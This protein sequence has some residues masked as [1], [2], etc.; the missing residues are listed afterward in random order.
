MNGPTTIALAVSCLALGVSLGG[1]V[2]QV[3][4]WFWTGPRIRVS[5][6]SG[7]AVDQP[8][9]P[10]ILVLVVSNRGRMPATIDQWDFVAKSTLYGVQ[11]WK[12]GPADP[13]KL[14]PYTEARWQQDEGETRQLL[15]QNNLPSYAHRW[16]MVPAI[17]IG[18]DWIYGKAPIR[19]WEPGHFGPDPRIHK[20]WRRFMPRMIAV[21]TRHGTGWQRAPRKLPLKSETLYCQDGT[22]RHA[23]RA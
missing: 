9:H 15:V 5:S 14:E 7:I 4:A 23:R 20:P 11:A 22:P 6:L 21:Q 13:Y 12:S 3:V 1:L 19:I 16:D 17:R 10:E 18:E 8:D 2:W